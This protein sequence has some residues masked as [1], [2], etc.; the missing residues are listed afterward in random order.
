MTT[1]KFVFNKDRMREA[2]QTEDSLLAPMREHAIKWNIEEPEAGLFRKSGENAL[3][4]ISM[5]I[6]DY[7]KKDTKFVTFLDEWTLNV[8]GV[9]DDCISETYDMFREEGITV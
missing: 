3:C 4:D 6:V 2:G 5:F 7:P 8:D 9:L 1:L